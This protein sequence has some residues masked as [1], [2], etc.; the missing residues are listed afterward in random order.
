MKTDLEIIT[1]IIGPVE[2]MGKA[3]IDEGRYENLQ[4]LH[5]LILDLVSLIK[6]VSVLAD[7]P[8]YSMSKA[9]RL[10]KK[11]LSDIKLELEE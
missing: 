8:E 3:Y 6:D 5:T 11:I 7:R 2:P 4:D 10:S 1:R 9:G